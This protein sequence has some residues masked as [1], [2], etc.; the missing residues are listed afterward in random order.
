MTMRSR[1]CSD[2]IRRALARTSS[3]DRLGLSSMKIG[4]SLRPA[5]RGGETMPVLSLQAAGANRQRVHPPLGR[6]HALH[7]LLRRHLEA[8]HQHLHVQL[9]PDVLRDR[10]REGRVV[11][12]DVVVGDVQPRRWVTAMHW[13]SAIRTGSTDTKTGRRRRR[14]AAAARPRFVDSRTSVLG[15]G[16]V[17]V[18]D[19]RRS[20]EPASSP[21]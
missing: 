21:R 10:E 4:A 7:E 8:E 9:D 6:E 11:G 15:L 1:P 13:A 14:G 20:A 19:E 18:A 12:D 16:V 2:F 3:T 17:D 5:G